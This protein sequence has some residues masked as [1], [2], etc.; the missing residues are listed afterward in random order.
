MY[1][2]KKV[3]FLAFAAP[4]RLPAYA[5]VPTVSEA[6]GPAGFEVKTWVGLFAPTGTPKATIDKLNSDIGKVMATAE[7]KERLAVLG[8]EPVASTPAEFARQARNEFDL[9]AFAYGGRA[10][11]PAPTP[12]PPENVDEAL[13]DP[14]ADTTTR[15]RHQITPNWRSAPAC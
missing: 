4:K 10:E 7:V 6:G 3:K 2:A 1:Q 8:F 11:A 5:D 14:T 15:P 12:V 9:S 13:D